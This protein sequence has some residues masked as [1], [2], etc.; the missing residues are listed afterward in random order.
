[1]RIQLQLSPNS[2][3]VPFSYLVDL[4]TALHTWL[5][6]NEIHDELSLYS[7]GWL[8]GGEK[9]GKNLYFPNGAT[10]NMGFWN[11]DLGW[12]L[13]RGIVKDK[14]LAY[15]MNVEKAIELPNPKFKTP[16]RFAVD[17]AVL[18]RDSRADGSRECILWNDIRS[19]VI[20]TQ[21]L[22]LKMQKAGLDSAH[23]EVRVKFDRSYTKAREKVM[24]VKRIVGQRD[25]QHKGSVCPV[26][27]EGTPEAI[28][29]AWTVG[30]GELTG[31][32]FGALI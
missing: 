3:P 26:I 12:D 19:D 13:A 29:F 2:K 8:T 15:G 17:G 4:R 14:Y 21:K 18:I 28:R 7:L 31:S 6:P 20:L 1:M 5:G 25:I 10:W 22:V 24:V 23:H 32:G 27:I 9:I 11:D 30:I 16:T